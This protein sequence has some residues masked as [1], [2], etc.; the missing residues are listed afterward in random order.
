[1]SEQGARLR[2]VL[3]KRGYSSPKDFADRHGLSEHT[4][5]AHAKGARGIPK[6]AAERYAMLLRVSPA[7]LMLGEGDPN[8]PTV[9]ILGYV[10]AGATV[11]PIDD[12]EQGAALDEAPA[13]VGASMAVRVRGRGL[14]PF[15]DG[16]TLYL[17]DWA[18][19]VP[20]EWVSKF[21]LVEL[22]DG[23]RVLRDIRPGYDPGTWNLVDATGDVAEN[24][25]V[26]RSAFVVKVAQP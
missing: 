6:P 12:H 13:E 18:E 17:T 2:N 24:V 26:R 10:G 4:V 22:E 20:A 19:G 21:C 14:P 3:K 25:R 23:S 9:P 15:R 8:A 16:W 7:W 1:M 5:K 11:E